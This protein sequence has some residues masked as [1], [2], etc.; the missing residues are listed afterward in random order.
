MPKR[1]TLPKN[2][3][4]HAEEKSR[5]Q[6][7]KKTAEKIQS[8]VA[9][10]GI[11]SVGPSEAT[12]R[13]GLAWR[14]GNI[15]SKPVSKLHHLAKAEK[16]AKGGPA[17]ISGKKPPKKPGVHFGTK[18][19]TKPR[20][21]KFLKGAGKLGRF[22][23]KASTVLSLTLVA[24]EAHAARKQGI[25]QMFPGDVVKNVIKRAKPLPQR[26]R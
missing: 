8:K 1:I 10:K 7:I 21:S 3:F 9:K 4:T 2:V 14:R 23:G 20:L 25:K 13:A 5:I 6:N 16:T 19:Y 26:K 22:A 12:Y 15:K 18:M 11:F 24:G 17:F